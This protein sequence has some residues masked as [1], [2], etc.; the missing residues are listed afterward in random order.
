MQDQTTDGGSLATFKKLYA[1]LARAGRPAT[2]TDGMDFLPEGYAER[3]AKRRA[4]VILLSLFGVV[5]GA[6]GVTWHLSE[7][8]LAAAEAGFAEVDAEYTHAARR[9][10]QFRQMQTRQ[11][12]VADR[13]ELSASLVERMPRS[14]LLAEVTNTLPHGVTL[15]NLSLDAKRLAPPAP[16]KPAPGT[17]TKVV[18]QPPA[19]LAYDT[20]LG[21]EGTALSEGQV[22]DYINALKSGSYFTSVDLKWVRREKESRDQDLEVR[23]FLIALKLDA[24]VEARP[25]QPTAVAGGDD[26]TTPLGGQP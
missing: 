24:D 14:N 11:K 19:P 8:S 10:E 12:S 3:R 17:K 16:P 1:K 2:A 26:M 23:R 9:I 5:V 13:W 22:S 20:T 6:I 25:V 4:D 7:Q 21:L 18:A 15:S